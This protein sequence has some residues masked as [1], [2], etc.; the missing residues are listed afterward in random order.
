VGATI[1]TICVNVK[2]DAAVPVQRAEQL[3]WLTGASQ[4]ADEDIPTPFTCAG[5]P[6]SLVAC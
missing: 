5:D 1:E 6:L 2:T 3:D 4:G